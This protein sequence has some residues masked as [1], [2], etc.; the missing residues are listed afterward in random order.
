MIIKTV[1]TVFVLH[2]EYKLSS[3]L[4]KVLV[5]VNK[6]YIVLFLRVI[7]LIFWLLC[8]TQMEKVCDIVKWE[9]DWSR[10][11]WTVTKEKAYPSQKA[12]EKGKLHG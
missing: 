6:Y 3:P 12:R 7:S 8:T 9:T 2:K 11:N 5:L 1:L 4:S 10:E